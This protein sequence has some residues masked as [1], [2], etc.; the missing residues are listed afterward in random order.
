MDSG[1]G[2]QSIKYA[3]LDA[4]CSRDGPESATMRLALL[5]LGKCMEPDGS[6]CYPGTEWIATAAGLG[7]ATVKRQLRQAEAD[8]WLRRIAR[9]GG[10]QGWRRYRYEPAIPKGA[11]PETA[12][13]APKVGSERSHVTDKVGS[14]SA[15]GGITDAQRWDQSDPGLLHDVSSKSPEGRAAS[16]GWPARAAELWRSKV[17]EITPGRIGKAL[18]PLVDAHGADEVLVVLAYYLETERAR[19]I[20]LKRFAES[21]VALRRDERAKPKRGRRGPVEYDE[22][23]A[24]GW[25][26]SH[27]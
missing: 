11:A 14:L 8:G 16:G 20:S 17:G 23:D 9:S 18:Q 10:G 27:E 4:V 13:P 24:Q 7:V 5:V 2:E 3:W 21:Y 19:F 26:A 6:R 1:N 25:E 22:A 15:E 12:P